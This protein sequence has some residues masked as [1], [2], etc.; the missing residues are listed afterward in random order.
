MKV[1]RNQLGVA[2][3]PYQGKHKKVLTVCSAGCLRSPT[4]AHILSSD[5]FNFN[6]RACGIHD[7]FAIVPL[8]PTLVIWA[9]VI[10]VMDIQQQ[11][12][13]ND[14]QNKL[15][16]SYGDGMYDFDY[17]Q[18]INLDIPDDFAYRDPR[19]VKLMTDKFWDIFKDDLKVPVL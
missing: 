2:F 7:D 9:D 3:N 14:M 12:F 4:A 11:C 13:V 10:L 8:T 18:V 15:A 6:T 16:A 17:K 19:L 5:P 1:T